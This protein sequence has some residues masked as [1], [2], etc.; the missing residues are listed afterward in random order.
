MNCS[1]KTFPVFPISFLSKLL[2]LRR[3]HPP[4]IVLYI[5]PIRQESHKVSQVYKIIKLDVVVQHCVKSVHIQSYLVRMRE[6][7]SQNYFK[8][9]HFLRSG[10]LTLDRIYHTKIFLLH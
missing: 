6:S 4:Q 2:T 5:K 1:I 9:G 8:Y 10:I 3:Y 7:T